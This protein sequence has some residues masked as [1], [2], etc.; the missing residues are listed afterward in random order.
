MKPGVAFRIQY[1]VYKFVRE[2]RAKSGAPL[3]FTTRAMKPTEH[4]LELIFKN[5]CDEELLSRCG[6]GCLTEEAQAIALKEARL[7]GLNPIEAQPAIE[8]REPYF[9]DLVIIVRNLTST[10]AH[11]YK[12]LLEAAGIPTE[13][14]DTN[15]SRAYVSLYSA[16]L[17]VPGT[18]VAEAKEILA[19]LKRGDF[20]LDDEFNSDGT[21]QSGR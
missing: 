13:A 9:G 3:N 14:G 4:E 20:A 12:T 15:F 18:L 2:G 1:T 8:E 19:A 7:R 21:E 5:L 16:S 6:S 10:E 11:L 17:K